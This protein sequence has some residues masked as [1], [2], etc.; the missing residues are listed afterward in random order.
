[1]QIDQK[2]IN[3]TY[4]VIHKNDFLYFILKSPRNKTI[5][6]ESWKVKPIGNNYI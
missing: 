5:K 1:M 3:L 2:M 6:F 4:K